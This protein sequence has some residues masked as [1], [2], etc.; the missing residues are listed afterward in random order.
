MI[1]RQVKSYPFHDK[2]GKLLRGFFFQLS[3]LKKAKEKL[4]QSGATMRTPILIRTSSYIDSVFFLILL[5]M[6][7]F[8]GFLLKTKSN[9]DEICCTVPSLKNFTMK[10]Y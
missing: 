4:M 10:S 8:K 1:V 7:H 9:K 5:I 6:C 2:K 3:Y